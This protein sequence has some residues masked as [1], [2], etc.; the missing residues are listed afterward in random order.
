MKRKVCNISSWLT[1]P[2]GDSSVFCFAVNYKRAELLLVYSVGCSP[3]LV[4]C[5]HSVSSGRMLALL[6]AERKGAGGGGGG[7][8][9]ALT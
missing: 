9:H 2:L 4:D 6:K 3:S 5:W 7:F 8:P 1:S